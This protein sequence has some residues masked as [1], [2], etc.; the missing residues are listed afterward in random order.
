LESLFDFGAGFVEL[1]N[2]TPEGQSIAE[3]Y[4]M[5]IDVNIH[6]LCYG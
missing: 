2:I 4:N 5:T 6:L 3:S 1:G